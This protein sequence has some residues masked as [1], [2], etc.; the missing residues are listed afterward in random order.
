MGQSWWNCSFA[1][2]KTVL[3]KII[4]SKL[5]AV[6]YSELKCG[7]HRRGHINFD[8]RIMHIPIVRLIKIITHNIHCDL[9]VSFHGI[10]NLLVLVVV[11]FIHTHDQHR[12]KIIFLHKAWRICELIT[13]ICLNCTISSNKCSGKFAW[14]SEINLAE[15][16]D[17]TVEI[18]NICVFSGR[19]HR[20]SMSRQSI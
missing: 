20:R 3:W 7:S 6:F 2:G 19:W 15:L 13:K 11:V 16:A 12:G 14:M 18:L 10:Q 17:K 4:G 8:I 5:K 9:E 1:D